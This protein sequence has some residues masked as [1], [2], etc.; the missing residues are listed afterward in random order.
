MSTQRWT[1]DGDGTQTYARLRKHAN[2]DDDDDRLTIDWYGP[3]NPWHTRG[4]T[5]T[6]TTAIRAPRPRATI[7][8]Y[9]GSSDDLCKV[10]GDD[11]NN[12]TIKC[13]NSNNNNNYGKTRCAWRHG[14]DRRQRPR[15]H[16]LSERVFARLPPS[17]CAHRSRRLCFRRVLCADKSATRS[18]VQPPPRRGVHIQG[19]VFV[20]GWPRGI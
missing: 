17:A 20:S 16:R 1:G 13:N 18:P 14:R 6:C 11:N 15:G 9:C 3:E 10:E 8:R 12:N 2:D 5:K 4:A 7:P 19:R